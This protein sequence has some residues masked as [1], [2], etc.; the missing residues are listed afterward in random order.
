ME[1][2]VIDKTTGKEAD[3]YKIAL[4]EDWAKGLCYCDMEGFAVTECGDL[5][6]LDECGN[7]EYASQDRFEVR[8]A[9]RICKFE[10]DII[11]TAWD[12]DGNEIETGEVAAGADM[13]CG[14][15]GYPMMRDDYNGWW[16]EEPGP[17]GGWFL[18]PRF[19]CCPKCGCKVVDWD[20]RKKVE[21]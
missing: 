15:C 6:L 18:T 11:N 8:F 4:T 14:N 13:Y 16:D 5:I 21:R 20:G 7:F 19:N 2:T 9:E 17:Y 3:D 1:F 10:A 12:E